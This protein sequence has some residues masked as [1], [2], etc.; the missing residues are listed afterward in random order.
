MKAVFSRLY[1]CCDKRLCAK[2]DDD[3]F[4]NDWVVFMIVALNDKEWI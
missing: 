3:V 2:N 4:S 1:F